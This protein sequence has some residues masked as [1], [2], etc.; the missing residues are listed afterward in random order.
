MAGIV[1]LYVE[2]VSSA[3]YVWYVWTLSFV[4]KIL[5]L[6]NVA[7]SD[8]DCLLCERLWSKH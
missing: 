1:C 7:E 4:C 2:T 6:L 3:G 5:L 8:L